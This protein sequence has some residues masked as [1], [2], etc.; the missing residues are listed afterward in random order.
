LLIRLGSNLVQLG[1]LWFC[2]TLGLVQIHS[3]F[4][5]SLDN[6]WF[7]Y[8]NFGNSSWFGSDSV[9]CLALLSLV[10]LLILQFLR[11]EDDMFGFLKD[12]DLTLVFRKF[13]LDNLVNCLGISVIWQFVFGNLATTHLR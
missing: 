4:S 8:L 6:L 12:L 13:V 7:F 2:S 9:S 1:F 11:R 5:L 10:G 3:G